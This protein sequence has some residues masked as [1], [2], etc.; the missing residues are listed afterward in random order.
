VRSRRVCPS[1]NVEVGVVHISVLSRN[2]LVSSS[3]SL[4][5]NPRATHIS[6]KGTVQDVIGEEECVGDTDSTF[7][8]SQA[9]IVDLEAWNGLISLIRVFK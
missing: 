6:T 8:Q 5:R 2:G 9:Q 1:Y 4:A 7:S 3:Y